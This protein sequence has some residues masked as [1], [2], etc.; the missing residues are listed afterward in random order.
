[1]VPPTQSSVH[2]PATQSHLKP[3]HSN[4]IRKDCR[5][6]EKSL[7][8]D[9]HLENIWRSQ[10]LKDGWSDCAASQY[11]YHLSG[12]TLHQYDSHIKCYQYCIIHLL[13]APCNDTHIMADFLCIICDKSTRPKSILL[14][15]VAA[16]NNLIK[17]LGIG[18]VLYVIH[19]FVQ[20]L[21]K[22]GTSNILQAYIFHQRFLAVLQSFQMPSL[23]MG[24]RSL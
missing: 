23:W 12:S 1:M 2:E 3:I 4:R 21:I 9:V 14:C 5:T 6:A 7:M 19:Y 8:E 17:S 16:M 15:T 11:Q 20:A 24:L 13:S 22:S 10:L 18:P